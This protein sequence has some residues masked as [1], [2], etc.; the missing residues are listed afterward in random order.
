MDVLR[1]S[2]DDL[3]KLR[4]QDPFMYHSIPAVHKAAITLQEVDNSKNLVTQGNCIVTRKSRVSTECSLELLMEGFFDD[5]EIF[6]A[7]SDAF[8]VELLR[9]AL[10]HRLVRETEDDQQPEQ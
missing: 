4:T 7:E 2:E 8:E 10:L 6:D 5:G 1:L 9:S 3:R